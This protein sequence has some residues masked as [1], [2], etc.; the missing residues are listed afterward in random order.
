MDATIEFNTK[1]FELSDILYQ[2]KEKITDNEYMVSMN[3]L[4]DIHKI[5]NNFV[6]NQCKCIVNNGNDCDTFCCNGL[7]GFIRC[8]NLLATLNKYPI[9]RNLVILYSLPVE[10]HYNY[11]Y[12]YKSDIQFEPIEPYKY[13]TQEETD[14]QIK[15]IKQLLDLNENIIKQSDQ[16]DQINKI[17]TVLVKII[18]T[19]SLLDYLFRNFG[20][21][22]FNFKL[23]EVN[24]NKLL[25]LS[26]EE[27][28][29]HKRQFIELIKNIYNLENAPYATFLKYLLPYY[30]KEVLHKE[31]LSNIQ[32]IVESVVEPVVEPVKVPKNILNPY[33]REL[34]AT[35]EVVQESRYPLRNRIAKK[36]ET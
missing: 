7:D 21:V 17:N 8:K 13:I 6:N 18:I 11:R 35:R 14:K 28:T 32:P 22:R 31:L 9:L 29:Y 4:N 2:I 27:K 36:M 19:I 24:Y 23:L 5:H 1:I 30:R 33:Q 34:R 20:F 12:Y 3:K 25:E 15:I 26:I 16:S 10:E